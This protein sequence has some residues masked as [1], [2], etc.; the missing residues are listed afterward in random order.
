M[1]EVFQGL[2]VYRGAT[3]ALILFRD[4]MA[5]GAVTEELVRRLQ[6]YLSKARTDPELRFEP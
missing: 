6:D 1:L 2:H 5:K 3:A 4:A